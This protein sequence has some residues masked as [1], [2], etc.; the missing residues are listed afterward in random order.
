MT[1]DLAS[2]RWEELLQAFSGTDYR[3]SVT[4]EGVLTVRVGRRHEALDRMLVDRSWAIITAFNPGAEPRGSA[5]NRA[6][7]QGLRERAEQAG[8]Q[9]HPTIN[10]DPSGRWPDEPGLLLVGIEAAAAAELAGQFGQAAFVSGRPGEI[11]RLQLLGERW[12]D[13]LPAWASRA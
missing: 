4:G 8:W 10:R 2:T 6:R 7:H 1:A 12:P 3:V 5:D 9:C 11:A 13:R